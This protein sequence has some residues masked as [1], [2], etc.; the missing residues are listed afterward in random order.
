MILRGFNWN[1]AAMREAQGQRGDVFWGVQVAGL[2]GHV[3]RSAVYLIHKG[4]GRRRAD[5]RE[6]NPQ[7]VTY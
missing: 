5:E 2:E 1:C 6:M 3:S 4:S 7:G